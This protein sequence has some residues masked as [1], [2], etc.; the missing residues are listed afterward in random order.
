MKKV[1]PK[2][3]IVILPI[4]FITLLIRAVCVKNGDIAEWVV[5]NIGYPL[6]HSLATV[7]SRVSFSIA[8]AIILLS[9]IIVAFI[10]IIASK[11]N[12]KGQRLRFLI[13]ILLIAS[14]L[15]TVYFLVLGVGYRRKSVSSLMELDVSNSVNSDSVYKTLL[16]LKEECESLVDEIDFSENGES[17][18][19]YDF[20]TLNEKLLDAYE[21]IDEKYPLL[22]IKNFDSVAKEVKCSPAMTAVDILGIYTFFTG[23]A[24]IN[25][26]YPDYNIPFTVA[27]ELAHQRG[28]AREDEANFLAFAV[29]VSSGDSY[30]RYS[31]YLN[32]FEYMASALA[33]S[34]KEAV[35]AVYSDLDERIYDELVAMSRFYHE[36]DFPL[37]S[38]ISSFLN[39]RYLKANGTEG[40]VSYSSVVRFLVAYYEN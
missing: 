22:G 27:H 9:P 16:I 6:R 3:A 11:K 5:V 37:F 26:H 38:K 33:Q 25:V 36:N 19:P 7:T 18:M 20:N 2:S 24:N 21:K 30:I 39:D 31:G 40:I 14:M 12:G 23:E 15:Y 32:A 4:I 17:I 29:T 1:I 8:E 13:S 34:E 28:I 10:I 35:S